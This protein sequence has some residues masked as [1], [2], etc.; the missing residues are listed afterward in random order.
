MALPGASTFLRCSFPRWRPEILYD[1]TG[2]HLTSDRRLTHSISARI[3]LRSRR[4][5]RSPPPGRSGGHGTGPR[6]AAAA[7][8]PR[9][10][11]AYT[12]E[13]TWPA[14]NAP[15]FAVRVREA[16]LARGARG[17]LHAPARKGSDPAVG[18]RWRCTGRTGT[19]HLR[20]RNE[21]GA[22]VSAIEHRLSPVDS[23]ADQ[24]DGQGRVLDIRLT[25]RTRRFHTAPSAA[26]TM[27]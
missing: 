7:L 8:R 2:R 24:G 27:P 17:M 26:A 14:P 10:I 5:R 15:A 9:P 12:C 25:R 22:A 3:S 13:L 4:C 16:A 1:G 20:R 23:S 6:C 21:G 11:S 18:R 19:T